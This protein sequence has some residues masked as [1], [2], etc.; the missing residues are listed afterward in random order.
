M[1][2]VIVA[3]KELVLA[4]NTR[5]SSKEQV[6]KLMHDQMMHC[7]IL[8]IVFDQVKLPVMILGKLDLGRTL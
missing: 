4:C 1:L 3:H 6:R 5:L 7:R 2:V 8:R